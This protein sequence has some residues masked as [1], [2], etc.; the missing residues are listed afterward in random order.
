MFFS[1]SLLICISFETVNFLCLSPIG[2]LSRDLLV[3]TSY[4]SDLLQSPTAVR[5]SL[6][7]FFLLRYSSLYPFSSKVKLMCR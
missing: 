2:L 4:S 5:F 6:L 7:L 3:G 1:V